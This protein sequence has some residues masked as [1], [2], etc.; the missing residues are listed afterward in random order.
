MISNNIID[1]LKGSFFGCAVGDALGASNEFTYIRYPIDEPFVTSM[2]YV[3]HFDLP[4]GSWTDDTSMM[5]CLAESICE[6]SY[7]KYS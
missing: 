3:K 7:F 6:Y 1:S 2:Q 5:L 4:A